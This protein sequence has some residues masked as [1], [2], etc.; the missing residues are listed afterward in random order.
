MLKTPESGVF[1]TILYRS[2]RNS[3]G[4][5]KSRELDTF[6]SVLVEPLAYQRLEYFANLHSIVG[7]RRSSRLCSVGDVGWHADRRLRFSHVERVVWWKDE[8]F[9]ALPGYI[10]RY[11]AL[12]WYHVST[13]IYLIRYRCSLLVRIE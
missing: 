8:V 9:L 6:C 2:V 3:A 10:T 12:S 13:S 4:I 7:H 1:Y 11:L 5:F